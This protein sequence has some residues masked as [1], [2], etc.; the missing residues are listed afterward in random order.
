MSPLPPLRRGNTGLLVSHDI[1]SDKS[2]HEAI[3]EAFLLAG[4]DVYSEPT[5]IADWL[6][7]DV[8]KRLDFTDPHTYVGTRIWD[9]HVLITGEEVRVY[10]RFPPN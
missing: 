10:E 3:V 2:L 7:P 6:E 9:H 1:E 8:L 4:M 5:Q